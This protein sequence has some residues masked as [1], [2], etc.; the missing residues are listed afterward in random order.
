MALRSERQQWDKLG[1][2]LKSDLVFLGFLK[3]P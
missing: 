1:I 2:S 3:K